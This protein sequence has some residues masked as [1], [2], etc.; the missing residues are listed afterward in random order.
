MPANRV[1]IEE[2]KKEHINFLLQTNILEVFGKIIIL[3]LMK[4][5]YEKIEEDNEVYTLYNRM[6]TSLVF[7]IP[8]ILFPISILFYSH[9][10]I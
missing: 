4:Y 8:I 6:K 9:L 7:L 1:E 3:G 10:K 2:A 5:L